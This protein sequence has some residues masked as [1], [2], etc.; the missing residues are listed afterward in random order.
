MVQREKLKEEDKMEKRK[1]I[2]IEWR[3]KRGKTPKNEKRGIMRKE[4]KENKSNLFKFC[5]IKKKKKIH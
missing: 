2:G 3:R 5:F 1:M 4:E